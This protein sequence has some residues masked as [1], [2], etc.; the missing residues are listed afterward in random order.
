MEKD[1]LQHL[2]SSLRSGG[3]ASLPCSAP[4]KKE[5]DRSRFLRV[6]SGVCGVCGVCGSLREFAGVLLKPLLGFTMWKRVGGG[7]A[8]PA[9]VRGPTVVAQRTAPELGEV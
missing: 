2:D 7:E 8:T 3:S 1:V 5:V 6:Y 9:P 4:E